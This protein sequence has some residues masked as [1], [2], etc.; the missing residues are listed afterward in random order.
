MR[1]QPN[2]VQPA[3]VQPPSRSRVLLVD[4][5]EGLT[6]IWAYALEDA[7]YQVAIAH[8]G[9]EAL[10]AAARRAYDLA[11]LDLQLPDLTGL[12]VFTALR[13][14]RPD[15]EGILIT[16]HASVESAVKAVNCG[17]HSYLVKPVSHQVMCIQVERA[18][19]R[20]RLLQE[21][22]THRRELEAAYRRE[23]R[24]AETLQRGIL[25]DTPLSLPGL[26]VACRY[27]AALDE[28][29]IGGD[30]YDVIPL[31]DRMVGL[32]IGDVSGKGLEAA[33]FT[34][35][36]KYMLYGYALE[37]PDPARVMSLLNQALIR[38]AG[39]EV[40]VT[41]FF[42]LLDRATGDLT[43]SNAGHECPLLMRP[44]QG[45]SEHLRTCGPPV[46]AFPEA[47][48]PAS[49]AHFGPE[50]SLLLYTDGASDARH[51]GRWL[52]SDGLERLLRRHAGPDPQETLAD[53][54][55]GILGFARGQLHDDFAFMLVRRT[56][57][58]LK[59]LL[60]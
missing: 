24:I 13:A 33:R 31:D 57:A 6:H 44:G 45:A 23:H 58:D 19:E 12:E 59:E 37:D 60:P 56:Y 16:A 21:R 17:V 7:G 32:V 22:E 9:G 43:F 26:R 30:F 38:R 40:F 20:Q 55:A 4:D 27:Q 14:D 42:G 52:G 41:L 39:Y 36:T 2:Q 35:L 48:Y 5:N 18:L 25:G 10:A 3:R 1:E 47:K 11:I 54:Y 34:A 46:G 51:G 28:A 49:L 8:S 50:D 29:E 15:M 53:I